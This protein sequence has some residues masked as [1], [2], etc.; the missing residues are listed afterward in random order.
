MVF[1]K[2]LLENA[3]AIR[4]CNCLRAALAQSCPLHTSSPIARY[5]KV[6][7][8][9][10]KRGALSHLPFP[11]STS[12]L[13]FLKRGNKCRSRN[14]RC[15]K[16]HQTDSNPG[17]HDHLPNTLTTKLPTT[18]AQSTE[19]LWYLCT[20]LINVYVAGLTLTLIL[21]EGVNYLTLTSAILP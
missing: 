13:E 11:D 10:F 8:P 2:M 15:E 19:N 17:P 3:L 14:E 20:V 5:R 1:T 7:R 21:G 12:Y 16:V 18:A 4:P 6:R 9:C